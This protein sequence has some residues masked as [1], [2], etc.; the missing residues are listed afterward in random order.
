M[1]RLQALFLM[2]CNDDAGVEDMVTFAR[3]SR[4]EHNIPMFAFIIILLGASGSALQAFL[5]VSLGL[6]YSTAVIILALVLAVAALSAWVR[7][8]SMLGTLWRRIRIGGSS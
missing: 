1:R 2:N 7:P 6:S 4:S 8:D 5:N 3:F